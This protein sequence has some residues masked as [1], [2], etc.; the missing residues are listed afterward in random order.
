MFLPP[1]HTDKLNDGGGLWFV[2]IYFMWQTSSCRLHRVGSPRRQRHCSGDWQV[3][4]VL[5]SRGRPEHLLCCFRTLLDPSAPRLLP[6]L[7]PLE[8]HVSV[9]PFFTTKNQVSPTSQK[10]SL[11]CAFR[12]ASLVRIWLWLN[13]VCCN[14]KL[15]LSSSSRFLSQ[16]C[17]MRAAIE[18]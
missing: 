3:D 14:R 4:K 10:N 8:H 18:Q 6:F 2:D 15:L 12:S 7:H 1:A 17:V 13:S 11:C 5:W 16:T 9:K